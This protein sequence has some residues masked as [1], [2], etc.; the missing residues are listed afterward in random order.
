MEKKNW[1]ENLNQTQKLILAIA[2]PVIL[3]LI[4]WVIAD[5]CGYGKIRALDMDYTWGVWFFYLLIVGIFE[6][7]LF[8]DKKRNNKH[9]ENQN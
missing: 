9:D 4:S 2:I 8:S 3:L 5:S 7:I 1:R 6:F